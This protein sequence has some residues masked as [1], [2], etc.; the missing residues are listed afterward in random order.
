MFLECSHTCTKRTCKLQKGIGIWTRLLTVRQGA[1]HYTTMLNVVI[2]DTH[3]FLCIKVCV[4][5]GHVFRRSLL[6]QSAT[7][8]P[9]GQARHEHAD[10]GEEH[11]D[12][13]PRIRADHAADKQRTEHKD[14][15]EADDCFLM[16][17]KTFK[18]CDLEKLL[19]TGRRSTLTRNCSVFFISSQQ[20]HLQTL[21]NKSQ[22]HGKV[23]FHISI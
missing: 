17:L 6:D 22:F 2:H 18:C 5:L 10:V 7:Q 3:L 8:Q 13:V 11:P 19:Q 21:Y 4:V 14:W 15:Q 9:D 16:S 1:N 20:N 23:Y 12:P